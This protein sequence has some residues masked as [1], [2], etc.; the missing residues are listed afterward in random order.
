VR[1][2]ATWDIPRPTRNSSGS[3]HTTWAG[4]GKKKRK[5]SPKSH[6]LKLKRNTS[7]GC[8]D[9]HD[10]IIRTYG[11]KPEKEKAVV[12]GKKKWGELAE[13][14]ETTKQVL[15]SPGHHQEIVSEKTAEEGA[16]KKK[17]LRRGESR[18]SE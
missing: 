3:G 18:H 13:K 1:A 11:C 16:G 8:I 10:E 4:G 6:L 2:P 15:R 5:G 12:R 14:G 17:R 7:T 9:G